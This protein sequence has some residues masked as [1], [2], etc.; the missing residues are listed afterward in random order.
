MEGLTLGALM[1]K[2]EDA[3]DQ[4]TDLRE[5]LEEMKQGF[6]DAIGD[7]EAE[8]AALLL[9]VGVYCKIVESFVRQAAERDNAEQPFAG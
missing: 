2:C 5:G 8:I 3:W 7:V 4:L 6:E 9:E 1:R